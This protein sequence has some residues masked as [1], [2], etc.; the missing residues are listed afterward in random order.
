VKKI[1]NKLPLS[2]YLSKFQN[3][4]YWILLVAK[5]IKK[6]Y[7]KDEK[8]KNT[9]IND[10]EYFDMNTDLLELSTL[11]KNYRAN[12]GGEGQN[13]Y[14]ELYNSVNTLLTPFSRPDIND[15]DNEILVNGTI[16]GNINAIIDNL[17]DLYSTIV[18]NDSENT[19]KFVIQRYNLGIDR[20]EA[21]NLKGSKMV[22]HR[23][24]LTP[25]DNISI[26][27]VLTLPEPTIRF[28]QINLPGSNM[29]V[30]ANLNLHFLNYW[31]LLKQKTSITRVDIDS[32]NKEIEYEDDNFVDDI[33]NYI[34]D[35]S[36]SD[37]P[38]GMSDIDI[39]NQF[40]KIIVPK[41]RV[42]FNLVKKY[43]KGRLSMVDLINYMEPFLIYTGDLTYMQYIEFN[44]FI[45][46]KIL[47][48]N[49]N[50]IEH[51]RAFSVLKNIKT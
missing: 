25:N 10:I 22:A 34:L 9:D 33:K 12:I 31:Q 3:P 28:S 21:T 26:K 38:E 29:L 6:V 16:T 40:L 27:S 17:G 23:V 7:P 13:K 4:L 24:K 19:R 43:I 18:S 15:A 45:K 2:E 35:F 5:N 49:K 11:F 44:K 50:Y 47:Q 14:A 32:L 8:N 46:S 36:K 37:K 48:Y 39:Y 1:A 30:K 20:L 51:S 42:L 41:I